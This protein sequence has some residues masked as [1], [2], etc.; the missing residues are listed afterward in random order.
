MLLHELLFNNLSLN[1]QGSP[2]LSY[3]MDH[4]LDKL[5]MSNKYQLHH[6]QRASYHQENRVVTQYYQSSHA[7]DLQSEG[8]I[9]SDLRNFRKRHPVI[10]FN[11]TPNIFKD[12]AGMVLIQKYL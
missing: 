9:N 8:T 7:A 1:P 11:L 10:S 5:E 6:Q 2:F 4:D 12:R 3:Q